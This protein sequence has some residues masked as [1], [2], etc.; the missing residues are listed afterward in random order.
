MSEINYAG[1]ANILGG[2]LYVLS[3][4]YKVKDEVQTTSHYFRKK[5][6]VVEAIMDSLNDVYIEVKG[7]INMTYA[8]YDDLGYAQEF[9][10][11]YEKDRR[12]DE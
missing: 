5:E 10:T 1:V 6:D 4:T 3:K 11:L 12:C 7:L 2:S 8:K 9:F